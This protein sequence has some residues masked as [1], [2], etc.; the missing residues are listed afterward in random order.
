MQLSDKDLN[1]IKSILETARR[2]GDYHMAEAACV[3]IK[4][5]LRSNLHWGHLSFLKLL[6]DYNYLSR[7]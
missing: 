3:K 6:K 4:S 1:A 2:K 5:P 7:K